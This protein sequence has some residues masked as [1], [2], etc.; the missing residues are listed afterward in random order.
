MN[1]A[2]FSACRGSAARVDVSP[3]DGRPATIDSN[4]NLQE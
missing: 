3:T 1:N 2:C 4:G